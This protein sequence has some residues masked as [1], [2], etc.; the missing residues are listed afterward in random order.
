MKDSLSPEQTSAKRGWEEH[1]Q[2]CHCD[3]DNL[4]SSQSGKGHQ[5]KKKSCYLWNGDPSASLLCEVVMCWVL[6]SGKKRVVTKMS[7]IKL[8]HFPLY[9][10]VHKRTMQFCVQGART[11]MVGEGMSKGTH[12][13]LGNLED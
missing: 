1:R 7:E 13:I 3:S 12:S 9:K 11:G 6:G 5:L 10:T 2:D 8:Q 4:A